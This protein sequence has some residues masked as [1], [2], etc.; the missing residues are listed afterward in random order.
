[1]PGDIE[2]YSFDFSIK[3]SADH[4]FAQYGKAVTTTSQKEKNGSTPAIDPLELLNEKGFADLLAKFGKSAITPRQ[5]VSKKPATSTPLKSENAKELTESLKRIIRY[6]NKRKYEE[7]V[8]F[9]TTLA[10][11]AE[12]IGPALTIQHLLPI[13]EKHLVFL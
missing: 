9:A 10:N 12:E 3:P 4:M 7:R 5:E 1:M 2:T 8:G 13:I 6:N 11:K